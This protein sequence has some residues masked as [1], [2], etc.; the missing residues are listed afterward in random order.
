M[1]CIDDMLDQLSRK[2]I[3]STPDAQTGY[4]VH[5]D[6]KVV[7]REDC[8]HYL[9]WPEYNGLATFQHLMQRNE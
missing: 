8:I 3:F 1:P 9:Y 6:G 7:A 4:M 5:S 2:Q